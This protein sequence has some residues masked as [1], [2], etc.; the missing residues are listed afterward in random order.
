MPRS[1]TFSDRKGSDIVRRKQADGGG[2]GGGG[3]DGVE[4][5]PPQVV[6]GLALAATPPLANLGQQQQLQ[7]QVG[8]GWH[9]G[10]GG[11]VW[12]MFCNFNF[13]RVVKYVYNVFGMYL[14]IYDVW[15]YM[16]HTHVIIP[17]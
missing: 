12:G 14:H 1:N 3:G 11:V 7:Q 4:G 9:W 5:T 17:S 2:G 16:Y 10:G 13:K 8:I 15:M 6:R